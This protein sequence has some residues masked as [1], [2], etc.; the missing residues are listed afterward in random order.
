MRCSSARDKFGISQSNC[1]LCVP[2]L[3]DCKVLD[4]NMLSYQEPDKGPPPCAMGLNMK[5]VMMLCI[6]CYGLLD[7][8]QQIFQATSPTQ[9]PQVGRP[10]SQSPP[11]DSI[12]V[13]YIDHG[14]AERG[15]I[16]K[17]ERSTAIRYILKIPLTASPLVE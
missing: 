14:L 8:P 11:P 16:C 5:P 4:C 1:I 15:N 10:E 2:G 17:Q 12:F 3:N 7:S 9:T 6:R 13:E